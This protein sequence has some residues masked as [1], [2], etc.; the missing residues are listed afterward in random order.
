MST[1]PA[2]KGGKYHHGNL[3][4]ALILAALE[5]MEDG[6]IERRS[7]FGPPHVEQASAQ[8]PRIDTSTTR[9]SYWLRSPCMDS[10][11]SISA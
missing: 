2:G 3:A 6:G 11:S 8:P 5:L 7:R 9:P 1:A 4:E 10:S